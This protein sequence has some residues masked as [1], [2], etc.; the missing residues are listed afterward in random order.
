MGRLAVTYGRAVAAHRQ[1]RAHLDAARRGLAGVTAP[2]PPPETGDMVQRLRRVGEALSAVS[3]GPEF[4][5]RPVPIR[6]GEAATS[7][8][9]FP[10][11]VPLVGGAHLAID[12]DARDPRTGAALRSLVI[13]LLMAAPAGSVRVVAIDNAALGA[14]FLPLRPLVD[15][16][17]LSPPATSDGEI[18]ALLTGAEQHAR[19]S[20]SD[21][22]GRD[23]LLLV[24]AASMPEGRAELTRL[25]ALTHAGPAAG[26]CVLA[27]GYPP[28]STGLEPPPFGNT[29]RVTRDSDYAWVGDPPWW[30]YSGDGTGL[31]VPV[32]LDG[33]PPAGT[34]AAVAERHGDATRRDA[35]LEFADLL[36]A[37]NWTESAGTGL[38][39][40]IGRNGRDPVTL[41]F[42]DATP[43]WLV[44]GRTGS[45]KTVFLLDVLYGLAARYS[46]DEL[47]LF[48]LDFKEGVSFTEFVPTGHDG[49]WIPHARAVGIESDREYGV[50][51]LREL[52]RELN[53]RANAL[54][55]HGVTKLADLPRDGKPVPR[56]VAV[57]DEFH[58]LF[59]GNDA[60]AREAVALLEEL[61][62]KGRSYGI[63]LVLAS[64]SMSGIEALYGKV[65][66]I[67][68]QFPLRVALPGGS[69][70]LDA[71][72]EAAGALPLGS[73]IINPAAG[74]SSANTV[75]RFPDAHGSAAR[76]AALRHELWQGRAQGSFP[77][78]V[79]KGYDSAH[80]EDDPT[81]RGLMPGGRRPMALVGRV[82]DVNL[83]SAMF[84]LDATPGRH[85]AV[86]GTTPVG[87]DVLQAATLS[88]ARQAQP[89]TARFLLAPL[90][91]AADEVADATADALVAAGH[92]V[93]RLDAMA[94]R[95]EIR[96]LAEP[97]A[98]PS[99]RTYLV[100][101]GMD[102]ASGV[103]S[104]KDQNYRSGLDDL[105]QVLR[106]GP[107]YGVH[108]L[109][110]W[111]GLRRLADDIGGAHNKDDIACLVALNVPGGELGMYLGMHDLAYTPRANRALLVDRHDQ[112]SRLIVPFVRPGYELD[113]GQ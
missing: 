106:H 47:A 99:D 2:P 4:P 10:V 75:V 64:Q 68:G 1:A 18:Q 110:W 32:L 85:L 76:V 7:D 70:V 50:A 69:G 37:R 12:T 74:L 44:G 45:G 24:V 107:A 77:P 54:K 40:V 49:S 9:G 8:G 93:T 20:H 95:E 51:V 28:R 23:R 30:P 79:F 57:I 103:L 48:L 17:V 71:L 46:P 43:H 14:T 98:Q 56:V 97:V 27:A 22:N 5:G 33:D 67:F 90:V 55:R 104:A 26:V 60:L 16:G 11:V 63:H 19:A 109:G 101:F 65:D 82:V 72:N 73:A 92:P 36:P 96:K 102:G 58:V 31:V 13:R 105:Q 80:V 39:T 42:D 88:L 78:A 3:A 35:S 112:R 87:A 34:I 113:E 15:A 66:S 59:A 29:T 61:A 21:P 94:L 62:R 53:R 83:T 108:L 41:A 91:A 89:G 111:R 84:M 6:V 100:A 81:Y 38:R 86:V 52:R 25:A